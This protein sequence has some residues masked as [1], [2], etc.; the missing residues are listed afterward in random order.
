[1]RNESMHNR[2]MK[3]VS[4]EWRKM[5]EDV[6]SY[7]CLSISLGSLVYSKKNGPWKMPVGLSDLTFRDDV[8]RMIGNFSSMYSPSLDKGMT[9]IGK[10]INVYTTMEVIK[11]I[12]EI[13][14]TTEREL[15]SEQMNAL[16]EFVK[17]TVG[18]AAY[19]Y[20][21]SK[22]NFIIVDFESRVSMET[23]MKKT[24]PEHV[25]GKGLVVGNQ[26]GDT[27]VLGYGIFGNKIK[28]SDD[29]CN[30]RKWAELHGFRYMDFDEFICGRNKY[31]KY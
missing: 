7:E 8:L 4:P 25:S 14:D 26:S 31:I 1:M 21:P 27:R 16:M 23:L 19:I 13:P 24:L 3:P 18:K 11:A 9:D 6:S 12:L 29:K 15:Y 28:K 10:S 22:V 5:C 30:H 20:H 2:E 17:W